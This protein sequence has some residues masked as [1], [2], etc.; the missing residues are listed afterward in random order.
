MKRLTAVIILGLAS[1]FA[2]RPAIAQSPETTAS[3]VV[4]A[5]TLKAFVEGAKTQMATLTYPN[6]VMPFLASMLVEGDWKHGNIYLIFLHEDGTVLF[7]ADDI[8]ARGKDLYAV[9]DDRGNT[10]VQDL[11]A[12]A[13]MGGGY[14]EYYWDDP[15]V[16]GDEDMPK[17]AYA[18][19]ITGNTTGVPLVIIGGYY[20]DLSQVGQTTLD[21]SVV[22]IPDVTAADVVDR[23]TLK[24]FVQGTMESYLV[25]LKQVGFSELHQLQDFFRE[26]G[27]PWRQGS[28]Y[29][30]FFTTNG[31]VLFHGADRSLETQTLLDLE[32][33]NGI[34]ILQELIKAAKS[35]DGYVEYHFDDPAVMGDEDTG[36]PKVSYAEIAVLDESTPGLGREITIVLGAGFYYQGEHP[37]PITLSVHP[38]TLTEGES[39]QIVTVTAAVQNDPIPVSTPISLSLSGTATDDDYSVSGEMSITIPH[40]T[41]S[42]STELTFTVADD[43]MDEPDGE[44]IILIAS[45]HDREIGS[46]TIMVKDSAGP[47]IVSKD[48]AVLNIT[49][50]QNDQPVADATVE[51]SRSI[52]GRASEYQWQGT[53]NAEGRA[54]IEIQ[55]DSGV[56]G[57]YLAR[58]EDADGNTLATWSSIPINGGEAITLSLPIGGRA[59]MAMQDL[60]LH[61]NVP[62]PF[63]PSTQ[64]AYQIPEAGHVSLAIY[65]TLGQQVRILVQDSQAPGQY[66]V[67][68]DGKDMYGREVSSGVY[69]YRLVHSSGAITRRLLL[70]K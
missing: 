16:E 69:I 22:P 3:E 20:Q 43:G 14:V 58:A 34:K 38:A 7:H 27:G 47:T 37:P 52:A 63:N 10:V 66:R 61:P 18:I 26:E 8:S 50:T 31:Y 64:I 36:S 35:G 51:F 28:I 19:S 39:T 17:T 9:R 4:D 41:A 48:R 23:E 40:D 45:H 6:A 29:F 65:N 56:S 21:I 46:A 55:S 59:Q 68:W 24:A 44:T 15:A 12:A 70:V 32:D 1:L 62:N 25:A 13:G 42:A 57:Y 54:T 30:F 53:T 2:V 60:V 33:I 67:T 49:L 11:I 5:E